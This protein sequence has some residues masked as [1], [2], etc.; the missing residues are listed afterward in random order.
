MLVLVAVT[1]AGWLMLL[2]GERGLLAA[3]HDA[4]DALGR[5]IIAVLQSSINPHQPLDSSANVERIETT[6]RALNGPTSIALTV[7]DRAGA[8][9]YGA[10][11][12]DSALADARAGA[13]SSLVRGTSVQLYAPLRA[14][15]QIVGAVRLALDDG[16]PLNDALTAARRLLWG[17][18]LV[19]GGLVLLFGAL[20][21]R[22]VVGPLEQLAQA[23]RQVAA[24]DLEVPPIPRTTDGDEVAR[25][26]DAFNRM[27]GSLRTQ[28]DQIV[29][30][31]KL[32]SGRSTR[33]RCRA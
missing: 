20:F 13:A 21:I 4:K 31:E 17:I 8:T 14:D 10:P 3:Q 7:V 9:I 11:V 23:A 6:S 29:A 12:D 16:T 22:R 19:D 25:L 30:Q 32:A 24:G 26:T 33:R 1:S 18:A 2:Y 5:Q 28:R 27:T 15:D